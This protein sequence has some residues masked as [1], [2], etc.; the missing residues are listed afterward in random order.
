MILPFSYSSDC[1]VVFYSL[2]SNVSKAKM[3]V[4]STISLK[5]WYFVK[6]DALALSATEYIV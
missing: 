1:A 4:V 2:I 6:G 5:N 3:Q